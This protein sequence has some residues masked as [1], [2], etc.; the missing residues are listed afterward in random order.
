VRLCVMTR[1]E[2]DREVLRFLQRCSMKMPRDG[3]YVTQS[4]RK[5]SPF[6]STT[7]VSK[8]RDVC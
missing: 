5:Q 2:V 7:S 4:L 8:D 3:W 6:V 1:D